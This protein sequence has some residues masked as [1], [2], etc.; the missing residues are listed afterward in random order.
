MKMKQSIIRIA[1]SALLAVA[2]VVG[3]VTFA[4]TR[5]SAGSLSTAIIAMFPK[6]VGEFSYADLK[7]ARKFSW[8]SQLYGQ[9]LPPRFRQFEQFLGSSGVDPNSQ[10]EEIA[11]ANITS[12]KGDDVVGI[13]LGQ[14]DP[15]TVESK[16]KAQ[17]VPTVEVQGYHLYA[18]G[19]G[20]GAGDILFVFFDSNTAAF[21]NRSV[22]EHLINVRMGGEETL[23]TGKLFPLIAEANGNGIIWAVLDQDH[24]HLAM[25]QLIPQ[26][27]QFPQAADI[28]SRLH[29]MIINIDADSGVDAHF[30][31]VC[32]SVDDANLLSAALQAGLMVRRYQEAQ[33]NP[34]LAKAL[35]QVRVTPTGDRLKIDAPVSQEELLSL[36]Q[37]KAFAS[38][39]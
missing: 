36:I 27:G 25:Q 34:S 20:A 21:G 23:L 10:V 2:L 4:P 7:A 18:F 16:L 32:N 14:F 11:W 37:T 13:A 33:G 29:A 28:I 22:L 35:D 1:I 38:P 26:A 31:A 3:A 12:G 9:V 24:T 8:F 15:S 6:N 30:Q 5:T 39:M 17:K 19:S